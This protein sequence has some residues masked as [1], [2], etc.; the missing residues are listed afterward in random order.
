MTVTEY[1]NWHKRRIL[2]I[3]QAA[4]T[5]AVLAVLFSVY[6]Q[7]HRGPQH[8]FSAWLLAMSLLLVLIGATIIG[9]IKLKCPFCSANL[10]PG[11]LKP[12]DRAYIRCPRC[13]TD[14]SQPMPEPKAK[15]L[16]TEFTEKK[17]MRSA[18]SLQSMVSGFRSTTLRE[19]ALI[20][21]FLFVVIGA[22]VVGLFL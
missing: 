15:Y 21:L 12:A 18:W 17:L 13:E 20:G 6:L 16:R 1:L 2:F 11:R 8:G 10:L 22:L 4:C 3:A 7:A 5:V 14:F 19:R 9:K